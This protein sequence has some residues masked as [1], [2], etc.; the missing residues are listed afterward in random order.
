MPKSKPP[1]PPEF[2]EEAVRLVR[3][4]GRTPRKSAADLGVAEQ[5]LRNWVFAA[6]VDAGERED[7]STDEREELRQLRRRVRVLEQGAGDLEKGRPVSPG[8]PGRGSIARA[9]GRRSGSNSASSS[10]TPDHN[11]T[12]PVSA[13]IHHGP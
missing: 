4:S 7:V 3:S 5:A 9:P 11:H 10:T 2:R 8:R 12:S 13:S 6:Q 1:Y